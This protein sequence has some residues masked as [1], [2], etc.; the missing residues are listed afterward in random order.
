MAMTHIPSPYRQCDDNYMVQMNN[1]EHQLQSFHN[2]L[3]CN[4]G[5]HAPHPEVGECVT[6]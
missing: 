4:E 3:Q 2:V 6:M 5:I 1:E